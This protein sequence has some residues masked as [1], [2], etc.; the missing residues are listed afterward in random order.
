MIFCLDILHFM[1]LPP[2]TNILTFRVE[3]Y[4]TF[5]VG[6]ATYMVGWNENLN[7]DP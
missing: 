6:W 3:V 2:T 1:C 5:P 7:N 4:G